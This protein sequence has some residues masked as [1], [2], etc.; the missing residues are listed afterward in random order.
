MS[1]DSLADLLDYRCFRYCNGIYP[2]CIP[3]G[4]GFYEVHGR[5]SKVL[6]SSPDGSAYIF[7]RAKVPRPAHAFQI[8]FELPTH[9]FSSL[10]IDQVRLSSETYKMYKGMRTHSCGFVE[11]RW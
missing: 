6:R 4:A 8:R 7:H 5:P 1:S 2:V 11:W 10:K 3:Q 9:S